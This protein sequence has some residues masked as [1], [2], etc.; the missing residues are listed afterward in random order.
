MNKQLL[1]LQAEPIKHD[2]KDT[3]NW[4]QMIISFF[5]VF[6]KNWGG[7]YSKKL[8]LDAEPGK[9]VMSCQN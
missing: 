2:L 5:A 4:V 9:L 6:Y 1:L 3:W 7:E 8:R